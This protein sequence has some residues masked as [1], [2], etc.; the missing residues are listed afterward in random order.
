MDKPLVSICSIT[1]N[2]APY[3]RECLDGFLMQKTDFPFEIIIHDDASTDGTS[4]I[5]R[6]YAEKYP[7]IIFPI[8]Q[9]EN[10]Y[11]K[12]RRF[13]LIIK[14]CIDISKGKYIAFC[15]GDDYWT[16]P[17]KL[18]K[19]IDYLESNSD[20]NLC[21]TDV[22]LLNTR[23]GTITDKFLQNGKVH[24]SPRF[25][26]HLF[27][28]G[29][30]APCTWVFRKKRFPVYNKI[31]ADLTFPMA[32]DF[33]ATNSVHFMT[34]CTAI[35]RQLNESA[36]HSHDWEKN[37]NFAKGVS[38]IQLDYATKYSNIISDKLFK[39]IQLKAYKS[40]LLSAIAIGDYDVINQAYKT[41]IK[42]EKCPWFIKLIVSHW[43][44]FRPCLFI[45]KNIKQHF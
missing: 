33:M 8:I 42:N 34:E 3:I 37:Y 45:L 23:T 11:S 24:S 30:I 40:I 14:S 28:R 9:L 41:I 31:Y 6:E 32:L 5:I 26:D 36:S 21:Y 1:Y 27:N 10:Q 13:D 2:H 15:E 19:Q 4:D 44:I 39:Q 20:C 35:Y 22:S 7:N 18:K 25:E 17:L 38:E 43:K 29:Y 16:D 12:H